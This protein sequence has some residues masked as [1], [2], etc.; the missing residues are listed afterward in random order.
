LQVQTPAA[1]FELDCRPSDGMIVAALMGAPI[2]VTPEV[3]EE[4]GTALGEELEETAPNGPA[5]EPA[6]TADE[7]KGTWK[8]WGYCEIPGSREVQITRLVKE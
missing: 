1:V 8:R 6:T 7:G 5:V 3:M 4:A 2:Y